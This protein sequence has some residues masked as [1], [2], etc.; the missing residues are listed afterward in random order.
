[1]L[2]GCV[3][4]PR[5]PARK[6][7]TARQAN[8]AHLRCRLVRVCGGVHPTAKVPVESVQS[9]RNRVLLDGQLLDPLT[10]A[11]E[12]QWVTPYKLDPL[13]GV[14]LRGWKVSGGPRPGMDPAK[15]LLKEGRMRL[16]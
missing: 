10:K 5:D 12:S 7:T 11:F 9:R 13:S 2:A 8:F 6:P 1:M 4:C 3:S 16:V 14:T 15:I